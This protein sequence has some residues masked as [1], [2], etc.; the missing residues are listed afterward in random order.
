[1]AKLTARSKIAGVNSGATIVAREVALDSIQLDPEF[2]TLFP[3]NQAVLEDVINRIKKYGYDKSQPLQIWKEKNLLIDG[4]TRREAAKECGIKTVPVYEHSFSD[5]TEAM[6]YTIGLQTAR[7]NLTDV[8]IATAILKLDNLK[9]PGRK[10]E[11]DTTPKGK[12][13]EELADKLGI[14]ARK[15]EKFRTVEKKAKP[16]IKKKVLS[17]EMTINAAY[18]T[19]KEKKN[20]IKKQEISYEILMTN[21][22]KHLADYKQYLAIKIILVNCG[23]SEKQKKKVLNELSESQKSIL[24]SML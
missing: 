9:N 13:S 1:M 24:L 19:T 15:I 20:S 16:A 14:S 22:I 5:I 4:H 7:R 8:E 10:T 3:I 23:F 6:E 12:S 11:A 2:E 18:N 21:G 17:G